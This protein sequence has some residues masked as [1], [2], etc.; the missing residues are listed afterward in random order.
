MKRRPFTLIELLVVIAIIAILASMLLPALNQ[1][2]EKAK[3]IYCLN[4]QKQ[5]G[6]TALS[7]A[8]A[9]NEYICIAKVTALGSGNWSKELSG[10]SQP[11]KYYFCPSAKIDKET[12]YNGVNTYGMKFYWYGKDPKNMYIT[13]S[14]SGSYIAV[15]MRKITKP[16]TYMYI[17]DSVDYNAGGSY[18]GEAIYY[19]KKSSKRGFHLLHSGKANLLFY[20]G[21]AEGMTHFSISSLFSSMYSSSHFD[22]TMLRNKNYYMY[23]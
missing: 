23:D 1:A 15:N 9:N 18:E 14:S 8:D 13:G 6:L 2:R 12:N 10:E 19:L 4:N 5:I 16:S 22:N 21:H 20:D 3:G 17:T 11:P 7:Y